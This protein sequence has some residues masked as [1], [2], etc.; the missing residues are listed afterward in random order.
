MAPL[1]A[2][3]K[4]P[5]ACEYRRLF[6]TPQ[7]DQGG[8]DAWSD[9]SPDYADWLGDAVEKLDAALDEGWTLIGVSVE[10]D[11]RG[12]RWLSAVLKRSHAGQAEQLAGGAQTAAPHLGILRAA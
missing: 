4:R 10:S 3:S 6:V 2:K 1:F 5:A 7:V 8:A 12:R 11:A 9:Q